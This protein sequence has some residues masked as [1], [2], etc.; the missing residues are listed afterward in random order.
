M[1]A[2]KDGISDGDALQEQE[3]EGS[4]GKSLHGV[5]LQ[6]RRQ[7]R[8][9]HCA[10]EKPSWTSGPTLCS[11]SIISTVFIN[12]F[13]SVVTY[14]YNISCDQTESFVIIIND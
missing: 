9:D 8:Q 12:K 2:Q 7:T 3:G 10:L 13:M 5:W 4:I 6:Q 14:I 1:R 11:S